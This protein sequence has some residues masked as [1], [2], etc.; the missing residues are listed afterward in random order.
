[1]VKHWTSLPPMEARRLDVASQ[2]CARPPF[3]SVFLR[4]GPKRYGE[5]KRLVVGVSDKVLIQSLKD[6]EADRERGGNGQH[7]RRARHVCP[8]SS[9]MTGSPFFTDACERQKWVGWLN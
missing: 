8:G 7:F 2:S 5:L 4:D 1:M 6:L 3:R 9:C